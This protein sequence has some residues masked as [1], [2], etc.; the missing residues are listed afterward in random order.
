MDPGG[1]DPGV[2]AMMASASGG[3]ADTED[4]DEDNAEPGDPRIRI[5]TPSA[6]C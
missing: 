1:K 5:R 3:W 6:E 2:A 4:E